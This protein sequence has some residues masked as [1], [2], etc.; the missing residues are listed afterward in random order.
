VVGSRVFSGRI[1]SQTNTETEIDWRRRP[2]DIEKTP[3]TLPS[4]IDAKLIALLRAFGLYFG[5]FDLIVTPEG[6]HVFLEVNPAGQ[7]LWVE[8]QTK[9]PI[10]E[11]IAN[12]LS[13]TREEY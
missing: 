3:I 5:A 8:A 10:T 12:E 2:F 1:N 11:A 4:D 6:R 13:E 9:L 7:Y